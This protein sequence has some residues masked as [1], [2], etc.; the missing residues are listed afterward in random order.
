MEASSASANH[1]KGGSRRLELKGATPRDLGDGS[2]PVGVQ[3]LKKFY[4]YTT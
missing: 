3:K 2:Y 1:Y 4:K